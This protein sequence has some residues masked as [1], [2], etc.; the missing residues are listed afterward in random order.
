MECAGRAGI[1][2][3]ISTCSV[4]HM[5]PAK[6]R[7]KEE[8]HQRRRY[9]LDKFRTWLRHSPQELEQVAERFAE[10]LNAAR[11]PVRVLIPLRG[12]SGVDVEGNPTYDPEEDQVFVRRLR[13]RLN[14]AVSI[15]QIDANME[16]PAFAAAVGEAALELFR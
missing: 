11:G 10:K 3:I 12:W 16:D 1:P 13:Q 7:Y 9:H 4:N 8:Y 15:T 2:Q 5:T 6:S 14:P